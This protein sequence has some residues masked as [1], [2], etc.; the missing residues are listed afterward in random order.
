M[1]RPEQYSLDE[2][3]TRSSTSQQSYVYDVDD[4]PYSTRE[5]SHLASIAEKKRLWWRN[6]T[7]NTLFIGSWYADVLPV[8]EVY[9]QT[10]T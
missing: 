4:I 1:T 3:L 10:L 6:A 5:D 9:H 2:P 7:I 8:C